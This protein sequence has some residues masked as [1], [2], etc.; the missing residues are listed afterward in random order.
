M[1]L[2]MGPGALV[3]AAIVLASATVPAVA[4]EVSVRARI[5]RGRISERDEL[6]L[7]VDVAGP[8]LEQVGP[9]DVT[10]LV[11]FDIAGGPGRSH[12]FQ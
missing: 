2:T 11:D 8:S 4:D 6:V 12:R 1:K 5:D 7:T 9:P 10:R 3:A